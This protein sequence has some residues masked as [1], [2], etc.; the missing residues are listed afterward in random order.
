MSRAKQRKMRNDLD[1]QR[2]IL[3][4]SIHEIAREVGVALQD[5]G[6]GFP[7]YITVRD[8]GDSLATIATPADLVG[9]E[10][11]RAS[12]IVCEIIG[13]WVG[14]IAVL[15]PALPCA[16]ANASKITATELSAGDAIR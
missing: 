16:I 5:A 2:A 12:A 8:S 7:V 1:R 13:N 9:D 15:G 4:D 3:R 11:S 14:S 10:W 6:F